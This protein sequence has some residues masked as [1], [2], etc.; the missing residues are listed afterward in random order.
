LGQELPSDAGGCRD[1]AGRVP[2]VRRAAS[3]RRGFAATLLLDLPARALGMATL[4]VLVRGLPVASFA[5]YALLL[6]LVGVAAGAAGGGVRMRYIRLTAERDSRGLDPSG[7]PSF[8]G[9]LLTTTGLMLGVTVVGLA[10]GQLAA[11][12]GNSAYGP[13]L[14]LSAGVFATGSAASDL[15]IAHFQALRRF[16]LAG[17]LGVLR[18]ATLLVVAV[19]VVATPLHASPPAMLMTFAGAMI[20]F[21]LALCA[22]M[23]RADLRERRLRGQRLWLGAEERWLTGYYMAAAGFAYV[24]LL[25]AGA[26]LHEEQIASLGAALRYLS[27]VLGAMPALGAI[28]RVRTSQ[29]DI[30]DSAARQREVLLGWLRRTWPAGVVAL[31]AAVALTP[32]VVPL[33]DGGRYPDSVIVLQILLTTALAAYLTAPGVSIVIAQLRAA[34]LARAFAI[35]LVVN[36]AGDVLVARP[37]G[38]VGIAVVSSAVYVALDAATVIAA[39]RGARATATAVRPDAGLRPSPGA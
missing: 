19:V 8:A 4:V 39:V 34:W 18:S 7:R 17:S 20:A 30:L 35:G 21:G 10:G 13:A 24:D 12:A 23:L 6:A 9:A 27:L 31:G 11:A 5:Q 29:M 22:P 25:V 28:L 37:L 1:D 32:L 33:I 38:V 36:F 26:L 15:A 3:F 2:H 16:T 14:V